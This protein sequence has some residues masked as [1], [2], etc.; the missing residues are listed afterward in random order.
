MVLRSRPTVPHRLT[1]AI[2]ARLE[3]LATLG[4]EPLPLSPR[5]VRSWDIGPGTEVA[6][7]AGPARPLRPLR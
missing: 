2:R 4:P 1:V 5:A 3:A 6:M 7:L